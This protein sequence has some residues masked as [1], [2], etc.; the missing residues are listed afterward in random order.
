[1]ILYILGTIFGEFKFFPYF[2]CSTNRRLDKK[3][4]MWQSLIFDEKKMCH[5]WKD[6]FVRHNGGKK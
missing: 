4:K 5:I 2:Y 1:M 3:R 6:D